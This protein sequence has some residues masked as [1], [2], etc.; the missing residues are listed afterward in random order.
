MTVINCLTA[1]WLLWAFLAIFKV[2]GEKDF[3]SRPLL[4]WRISLF[5][6][7][8]LMQCLGFLLIMVGQLAP[9][10][11]VAVMGGMMFLCGAGIWIACDRQLKKTLRTLN[12]QAA[13]ANEDNNRISTAGKPST[14][15]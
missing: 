15:R 3:W 12:N 9:N 13:L 8:I 7:C 14:S 10:F 11:P 2:F 5:A 1:L 4:S 6:A